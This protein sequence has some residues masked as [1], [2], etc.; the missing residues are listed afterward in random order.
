MKK[1]IPVRKV[2]KLAIAILPRENEQELWDCYLLNLDKKPI[3]NVLISSKGYGKLEGERK[4][5]TV[6][7]HFFER[8]GGGQAEKIEPIQSS[9][10]ELTNEF[11]V[12]F[13]QEDYMYDK[14]Y[15]FVKGA[16]SDDYLTHV[17]LLER[18]GVMIR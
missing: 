11:W 12:S 5:T 18:P 10:F 17:P 9:L 3:K 6:L 1:D 16:I 8:I 4:N 2:E 7:R 14:K 15:V 13:I